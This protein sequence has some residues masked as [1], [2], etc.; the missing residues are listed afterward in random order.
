MGTKRTPCPER[1]YAEGRDVV[2]L[3]CLGDWF[4]TGLSKETQIANK[5]LQHGLKWVCIVC[6]TKNGGVEVVITQCVE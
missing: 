1:E 3:Q 4:Y 6:R 2:V 5:L